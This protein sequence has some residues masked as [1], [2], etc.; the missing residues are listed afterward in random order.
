MIVVSVIANVCAVVQNNR[1]NNHNEAIVFAKEVSVKSAPA[2]SGTELFIL[3]EGTKVKMLETVGEWVE[4]QISDG[5]Q[6]W[7]PLRSVEVI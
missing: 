1:S 2:E 5:N 7:M 3:H 4:V 6:G